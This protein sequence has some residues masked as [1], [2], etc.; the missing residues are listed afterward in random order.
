MLDLH[1][2]RPLLAVLAAT[3]IGHAHFAFVWVA[4]NLMLC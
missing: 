4:V 3:C 2:S 1:V